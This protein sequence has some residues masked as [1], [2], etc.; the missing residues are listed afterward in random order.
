MTWGVFYSNFIIILTTVIWVRNQS[1]PGLLTSS[2]RPYPAVDIF[3]QIAY[4]SS[5]LFLVSATSLRS[6]CLISVYL[7]EQKTFAFACNCLISNSIHSE[8]SN[9]WDDYIERCRNLIQQKQQ[10]IPYLPLP[11]NRSSKFFHFWSNNLHPST[12]SF[13]WQPIFIRRSVFGTDEILA[14][15]HFS[16]LI[17]SR[18]NVTEMVPWHLDLAG[19][20]LFLPVSPWK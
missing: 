3:D 16:Y 17:D 15:N 5:P 10:I 7:S 4:K 18:G 6:F 19:F 8:T 1:V 14:F 13:T 20:A 2:P 9:S 12:E 11:M